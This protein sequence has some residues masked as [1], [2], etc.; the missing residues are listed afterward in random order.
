MSMRNH[1]SAIAAA[2]A[3]EEDRLWQR[4]MAMAEFGG[5]DGGGVNRAVFSA[6]DIAA[7]ACLLTWAEA[8]AL[9]AGVDAI[10]N[11]YLRLTGSDPA[12]PPVMTGSHMDSQ[13]QGGR[14]DGIYGV[15]AGLEAIQAVREAGIEPLRS[16][17]LVAWS[18]EEGGRFAPGAMGS[19]VFT[20]AMALND[21]LAATDIEG[22]RLQDALAATLAATPELPRRD[23]RAP[24]HAY[25]EAHIEQGPLLEAKGLPVGVVDSVQGSRWFEVTIDGEAA[26]AGTAPLSGRRDALRSAVAVISALQSFV[27]DDSDTVRFTV[28]RLEVEPNSPNT[29][30]QRVR[31]SIDLRHPDAATLNRLGDGIAAETERAVGPCT[32]SVR[33]SFHRAPCQFD[34]R[35]VALLEQSADALHLPYTRLASGAF[36]DAVFLAGH[37]PTAMIFV[38]CAEGISHNPAEDAS[39]AD[40]AAGTRL[41]TAGLVALAMDGPA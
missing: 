38:P 40:L 14:F 34:D 7:R 21:C 29:V 8:L 1:A 10:G 35:L 32:A 3:V 37:C 12:L 23:L 39:P 11:L 31:F 24:V 26:H 22:I 15:I 17:E 30:P 33:E 41:L 19:A 18:N 36:H 4:L 9:D 27:A 25:L 2:D 16:I 20:G 5:F 13:P 28:G 6:E